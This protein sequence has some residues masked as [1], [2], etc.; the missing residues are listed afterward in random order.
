MSAI[1]FMSDA[2]VRTANGRL[3]SKP[4]YRS[5]TSTGSNNANQEQ[6][7]PTDNRKLR[8]ESKAAVRSI[9]AYG[10]NVPFSVIACITMVRAPPRRRPMEHAQVLDDVSG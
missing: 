9:P 1:S 7:I 3:V 10:R 2:L 5:A 6:S 8:R 4:A